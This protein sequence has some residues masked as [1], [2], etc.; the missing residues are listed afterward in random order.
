MLLRTWEA[1]AQRAHI[2]VPPRHSERCGVVPEC[3]GARYACGSSTRAH[4]FPISYYERQT[5]PFDEL[6]PLCVMTYRAFLVLLCFTLCISLGGGVGV[7]A[8]VMLTRTR[9]SCSFRTCDPVLD[10]RTFVCDARREN[11]NDWTRET[12]RAA[13]AALF[14]SAS[15]A[16]GVVSMDFTRSGTRTGHAPMPNPMTPDTCREWDF[17]GVET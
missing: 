9:R 1:Y 7:H 11:I 16:S 5:P 8:H 13:R 14:L 4:T 3:T 17:G 15:G 2:R 6:F 12:D 10:L